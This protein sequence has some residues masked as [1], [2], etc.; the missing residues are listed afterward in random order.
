MQAIILA[1]GLGTRLKSVIND[2]AKPMADINGRPFLQYMFDYLGPQGVKDVVL[3]VG[4]K[5]ESITNHFGSEY[6]GINIAYSLEQ[7]PLGTGGAVRQ[8]MTLVAP[9]TS[10]VLVMNG[11]TF[12]DVDLDSMADFHQD[13]DADVTIALKWME[14]FERYGMVDI[15]ADSR[16][17][18]FREKEYQEEGYINGGIYVIDHNFF[19]SQELPDK[20]SLEKDFHEVRYKDSDYY[21]YPTDEYFIDI[22]VPEDYA[23]AKKDFE[24]Y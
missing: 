14:K 16:I 22:G 19:R 12:F 11:D 9:D 6:E 2:V 10:D 1:G 17:V 5:S 15:E 13:K 18:G 8:A 21:G 24:T 3:C 20:F 7:Q 4:Y 23:K